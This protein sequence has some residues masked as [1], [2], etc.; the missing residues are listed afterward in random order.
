VSAWALIFAPGRET[1]IVGL[2]AESPESS[3]CCG[4]LVPRSSGSSSHR[5][6]PATRIGE[7]LHQPPPRKPD[8]LKPQLI[9]RGL[10]N[11][12]GVELLVDRDAGI[13]QPCEAAAEHQECR[14]KLMPPAPASRH[15][16]AVSSSQASGIAPRTPTEHGPYSPP[17]RQR[18]G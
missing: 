2:K 7:A 16:L 9:V 5:V 1:A 3:G 4:F 15:R 17:S 6:I 14:Q 13:E 12:I 8:M 18:N 10:T 11:R